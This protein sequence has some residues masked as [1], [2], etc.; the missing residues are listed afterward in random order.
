MN[1]L[2]YLGEIYLVEVHYR[3]FFFNN[4]NYIESID[5]LKSYVK[6]KKRTHYNKTPGPI[7]FTL[8]NIY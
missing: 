8:L 3:C 4:S 7:S 1:I 6:M 2:S 5:S